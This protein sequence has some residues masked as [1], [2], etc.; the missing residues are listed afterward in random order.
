MS[1]QN[2]SHHLTIY[3]TF[4]YREYL[5]ILIYI[6]MARKKVE[7]PKHWVQASDFKWTKD[8]TKRDRWFCK[9]Y[10]DGLLSDIEKR[11]REI[12]MMSESFK[13]QLKDSKESLIAVKQLKDKQIEEARED[14][15]EIRRL[16]AKEKCDN[17]TLQAIAI[18][19]ATLTIAMWVLYF[20]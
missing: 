15:M 10:I 13:K 12:L 17:T 16:Y 8:M 19:C 2:S 18:I 3:I 4:V 9:A 6:H 5:Y 1:T 14:Y 20:L 7:F 11:D